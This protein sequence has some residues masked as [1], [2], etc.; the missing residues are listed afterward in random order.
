MNAPITD[1][2]FGEGRLFLISPAAGIYVLDDQDCFYDVAEKSDYPYMVTAG[3]GQEF[4][5]E[6]LSIENV[7]KTDFKVWAAQENSG[8]VYAACGNRGIAVLNQDLKVLYM[9]ETGGMCKDIKID[10]KRALLYS[11]ESENGIS[12]YQILLN[13]ELEKLNTMKAYGDRPVSS[14]A[15]GETKEHLCLAQVGVSTFS[16]YNVEEPEI[17][18]VNG[19]YH[20]GGVKYYRELC[21]DAWNQYFFAKGSKAL[22]S[23]DVSD[24]GYISAA[25]TDLNI[26]EN[27]GICI[28]KEQ[29]LLNISGGFIFADLN[30]MVNGTLEIQQLPVIRAGDESYSGK[31]QVFEDYLICV[32]EQKKKVSILELKGENELRLIASTVLNGFPDLLG[33]ADGYWLMPIKGLGLVKFK[34]DIGEIQNHD[35]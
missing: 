4:E 33:F 31:I 5:S 25:K 29:L 13:G 18:F 16:I 14:I 17:A 12:I 7:W 20:D 32:E 23:Y 8:L 22:V 10:G 28:W 24:T 35:L 34:L 19:S 6:S 3:E 11:A 30:E 27:A 26:S 21:S 2:A 15:L 9:Y 1:V